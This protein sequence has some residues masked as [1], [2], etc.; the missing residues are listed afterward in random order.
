VTLAICAAL[1]LSKPLS[2]SRRL[3]PAVIAVGVFDTGANVLVAFAVTKGAAGVVA[4]L[5]ALYPIVTVTLARAL[6][7]ERLDTARRAGGVL[8]LT[9]AALVAAG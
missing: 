6:L 2:A 7:G 4:V 3:L 5:S 1:A 9:G 8:A